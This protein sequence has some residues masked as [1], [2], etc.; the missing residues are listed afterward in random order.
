MIY[1]QKKFLL[2]VCIL[3]PKWGCIIFACNYQ[4]YYTIFLKQVIKEA[5]PS[6]FSTH[7]FL[8]L[9]SVATFDTMIHLLKWCSFHF[10]T[11]LILCDQS[12]QLLP[13]LENLFTMKSLYT[14][15][16]SFHS[17]FE[18]RWTISQFSSCFLVATASVVGSI[19]S[20]WDVSP[21]GI[22]EE[23]RCIWKEL[24]QKWIFKWESF[25]FS[26]IDISWKRYDGQRRIRCVHM[27]RADHH[28][29]IR[30]V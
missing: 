10:I 17:N 24:R 16:N 9:R 28:T 27:R 8:T 26:S 19:S 12:R 20:K 2:L 5:F 29:F 13:C 11:Y 3:V 23:R 18:S 1:H 6:D 4:V 22:E 30:V 7:G 14:L 21:S 25:S 15:S